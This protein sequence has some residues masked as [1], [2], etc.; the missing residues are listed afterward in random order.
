MHE[1]YN[2]K[3][4]AEEIHEMVNLYYRRTGINTRICISS[5]EHLQ[6]PRIKVYNDNNSEY[7][8]LSIED[9][10]KILAGNSSIISP[11]ILV[12]VREW[13]P[14][15]KELLLYYWEHPEMDVVEL[16]ERVRKVK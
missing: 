4:Q 5:K 2:K 6:T 14:L 15:N 9:T 1:I 16:V 3:S 13:I 7:L 12:Q 11:Q 10:P 8:S